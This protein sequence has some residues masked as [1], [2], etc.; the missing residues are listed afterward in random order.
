MT[1]NVGNMEKSNRKT[2]IDNERVRG[3][4]CVKMFELMGCDDMMRKTKLNK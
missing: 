4:R 3:G 1:F 2:E